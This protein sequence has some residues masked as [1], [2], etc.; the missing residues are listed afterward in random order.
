[1]HRLQKAPFSAFGWT[2]LFPMLQPLV[3]KLQ[4]PCARWLEWKGDGKGPGIRQQLF[5]GVRHW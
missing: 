3:V 4:V 1:M 2:T 5:L